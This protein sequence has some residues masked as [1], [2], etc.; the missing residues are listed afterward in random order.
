M[1]IIGVLALIVLLFFN[2]LSAQV[3]ESRREEITYNEFLQ[4]VEKGEVKEVLVKNDGTIE[5]SRKDDNQLMGMVYYTG[6]MTDLTLTSGGSR[7]HL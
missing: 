3:R 6:A 2:Y 5:I 7:G 1:V 4:W